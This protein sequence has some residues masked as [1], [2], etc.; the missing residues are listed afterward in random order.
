MLSTT[1]RSPDVFKPQAATDVHAE[2][3]VWDPGASKKFR[4]MGFD[5]FGDVAGAY[6]FKDGTGLTTIYETYLDG[7]TTKSIVLGQA[8]ILSATAANKLT[9]TG[10]AAS[11]I[12]G[13]I[14]GTE[15]AN[16]VTA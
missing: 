8:G 15:E 2:A 7:T 1:I 11:H 3:T 13:T 6:V 5:L 14:F 16:N 10:P 4:I 9:C 12:T